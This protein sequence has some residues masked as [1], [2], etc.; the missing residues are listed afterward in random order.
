MKT[1]WIIGG[2]QE[3]QYWRNNGICPSLTAAMGMGGGYTP[4][5]LEINEVENDEKTE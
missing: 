4:C 2:F 5:V 3:H 1:N